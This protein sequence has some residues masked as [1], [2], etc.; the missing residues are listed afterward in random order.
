MSPLSTASAVAMRHAKTSFLT[1]VPTFPYLTRLIYPS[2]LNVIP[3][4]SQYRRST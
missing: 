1:A 3:N 2:G 4:A